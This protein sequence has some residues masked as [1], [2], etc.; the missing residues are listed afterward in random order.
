[1]SV[2]TDLAEVKYTGNG[3]K[4]TDVTPVAYPIT[5]PVLYDDYGDAEDIHVYVYLKSTGGLVADETLTATVSGLN[6]TTAAAWSSLYWVLLVRLPEFLQEQAFNYLSSLPS[7]VI[8]LALDK[9]VMMMQYLKA[10]AAILPGI[11]DD[12]ASQAAGFDAAGALMAG[13]IA[14]VTVS[15]FIATLIDDADTAAALGTLQ[16]PLHNFII[17]G[18]GA[19]AQRGTSFTSATTPANSDDTYLLDRHILL[20]D[21]NDIVDVTQET[22]VVPTGRRT[23]WRYDV[24]TANKKFGHLTIFEKSH[25]FDLIGKTATFSAQ[26]RTAGSG[27]LD[28]IKMAIVSWSGTADA[29]TSDIVSAWEAEGTAPTLAA[30]WTYENTPVNLNVTTTYAKYSVTAAI[31]TASAA[32]IGLFVW[33]DVTGTDVGDFLYIGDLVLNEGS[34]AAPF[35][36]CGGTP[37]QEELLCYRYF[38][39]I[40]TITAT[41]Q[42]GIGHCYSNTKA[43]VMVTFPV[44]SRIAPTGVTAVTLASGDFGMYSADGTGREVHGLTA[45][46][47]TIYGMMLDVAVTAGEIVAGDATSLYARNDYATLQFTGCEL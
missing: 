10:R 18:D 38:P 24:E 20:S 33:S 29:P 40:K 47:A 34:V 5:F 36:L 11:A 25:C 4:T 26:L 19:V 43:L 17:N 14:G 28:N 9:Q 23:A 22:T 15:P 30:N 37:A 27:K 35:R 6:V 45:Y 46:R 21:G 1:M 39:V 7:S 42:F 3:T 31:D 32:N 13:Y 12:R 41:D 44:P 16:V 8:E 2:A